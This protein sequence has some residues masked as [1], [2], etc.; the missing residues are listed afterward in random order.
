[1]KKLV[2][3]LALFTSSCALRW[4]DD[5][6]VSIEDLEGFGNPEIV[7]CQIVFNGEV[8]IVPCV[9]EVSATWEI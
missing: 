9:I 8:P 4:P 2:F 5:V 1:M 6:G 7:E 3:L